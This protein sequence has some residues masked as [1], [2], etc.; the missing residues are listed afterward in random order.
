MYLTNPL[1]PDTDGDAY[2]DRADPEPNA[3]NAPIDGEYS[4]FTDNAT[5]TARTALTVTAHLENHVVYLPAASPAAPRFLYQ[6]YLRDVNDD[7]AFDEGDLLAS[8]IGIMNADGS[9]PRLLTDVNAQ[10]EVEDDGAIDAVPSPS[11]DGAY[12][13]FASDR[14]GGFQTDLRLWVMDID[15]GNPRM[16]AFLDGDGAPLP[17]QEIDADPF[18]GPGNRV[19]FKR[20]VL[21]IPSFSRL[22]VGDLDPVAATVTNLTLRTDGPPRSLQGTPAGDYDPWISPDGQWIASYR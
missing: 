13:L 21:G 19:A 2:D 16:V 22:Y 14:G 12:V 15:G 4:V 9:R 20:H 11:P 5:G 6:R 8:A 18:W 7:N 3:A 17:F 1:A 10:G